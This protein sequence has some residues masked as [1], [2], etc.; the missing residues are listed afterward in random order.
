MNNKCS[1]QVTV[2]GIF[3]TPLSSP[4]TYNYIKVEIESKHLKGKEKQSSVLRNENKCHKR[5]SLLQLL[6]LY[7]D[8]NGSEVHFL[9]NPTVKRLQETAQFDLVIFDHII[10]EYNVGIAAH[11]Q[12]PSV[13]INNH[14]INSPM[15]N[16]VGNPAGAA[17]T[18]SHHIDGP[19]KMTFS[20]RVLNH[21][22]IG[23]EQ[24]FLAAL[25][26]FRTQHYYK[27][28]FPAHL[29][30]PTYAEA[31]RNI[32]L[33]LLRSS[34]L[35]NGPILSFPSVRAVGGLQLPRTVKALPADLQEWFDASPD[36]V[37]YMSFGSQVNSTYMNPE[38][39]AA[40]LAVFGRLSGR[41]VLWKWE[42]DEL[43]DR[44]PNVK[45]AKW[46]PQSDVLAQPKVKLF[47]SHCGLGGIAE[48]RYNGV[49]LLGIPLFEDQFDNLEKI[50]FEGWAKELR[51]SDVT[52]ETFETM[53][54]Q[55][56]NDDD[57]KRK[58]QLA[59]ELYRDRPMHPLDEAVFWVEYVLR[60]NGA[61]HMQSQAVYLN[62]FQYHSLDVYGF[63][64]GVVFVMWKMLG[65]IVKL[66]VRRCR[67]D[68]M[69]ENNYLKIKIL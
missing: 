51:L 35:Q 3:P 47:I 48:A 5:Q 52:E 61:K 56:L 16:L 34:F 15:R 17:F 6:K 21:V 30:Y 14:A 44:P 64:I 9:S 26:Y 33:V 22:T 36:D 24:V 31:K 1:R 23:I 63:L 57:V 43:P 39:R 27:Q 20:Q 2:L 7:L 42:G 59:S 38:K 66:V 28:H 40:F 10:N 29:G 13:C 46:F 32:S 45:T 62:W 65:W 12:C 58:A 11:F 60:H 41:R 4:A 54:K 8:L 55:M 18:K 69:D 19:L 67:K 37:I 53:L 50:Q 25:D 68:E 49:P